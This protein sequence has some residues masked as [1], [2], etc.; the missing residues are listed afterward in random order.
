MDVYVDA[1]FF[2]LIPPQ[3]LQQ[4]GWHYELE[5]LEAPLTYKGVVFNE[6]KGA[7]SSPENLL[8]RY[9]QEALFPDTPYGVDSGGDPQAIPN[10]TYTQ[11]KSFHETYYH[12]SNAYIFMYG[13]DDP[14]TRLRLMS[15]YLQPFTRRQVD[16]AVPVQPP[17]AAPRSITVPYAA[18]EDSESSKGYVTVNWL[19]AENRDPETIL[20]LSIL[21]HILIGTPASPL[22]KALIDSGLGEDLVGSGLEPE[23]RQ[24]YFSTGLKGLSVSDQL[25]VENVAEVEALIFETL[26][27]LARDGIDPETVFASLNTTE[28]RLRENNTGSF[29]RGLLLMLRALTTW[30]YDGDPA[31]ALAFE[32]PLESIKARLKAGQPYFEDLI[33]R[34]LLNNPHRSTVVLQPDPGLQARLDAAE[35]ERLAAARLAMSPQELQDIIENAESLKRQQ[36][37]PDSPEVLALIPSLKLEDLDRQN[38]PIPLELLDLDGTPLLYHDLFTNGILYLDVGF[39]LHA[40]PQELLPYLPLFGRALVEIGT[41]TQDFVRLSQRIGRST[42]GIHASFFTS[43]VTELDDPAAWFFL[44]GKAV[45]SQTGELLSILQDILLTV[46]LDNPERF[47]QM[48]LES[49][50]DLEAMLV[51]AGHR[52]VN[53]RLKSRF[54]QSAWL[55]EQMGGISYL[56]FLRELANQVDQDWPS[57]LHKLETIRKLLI[58]RRV[59]LCNLTIDS[60]NWAVIQPQLTSFLAALPAPAASRH[61]WSPE[62]VAYDEALTI[63]AQVNYVGK[64]ADLYQLGYR[65]DGSLFVILNYLRTTYLWEKI[66]VQGGAYGGFATFD[67]RSGVFTY[68][69]YRDPNL[70]A[71]IENYDRTPHFLR[72]IDGSRL[73]QEE[74]TKSIIGVIGDLDAYQLPD[75]KGFSS[76]T[77]FLAGETDQAR[78]QRR[79]QVLAT[80]QDDFRQFSQVLE[81]V[82]RQ[83]QVVVLGSQESINA[84]DAERGGWLRITRVL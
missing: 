40:I 72:E 62:F 5:S 14:Q 11:F 18:G 50:A 49:K 7:Y 81:E 10:L 19:L 82:S 42:G 84:A 35:T 27:G 52:V 77:R 12:P 79:E 15:E 13:D 2:P 4:E 65:L 76:L 33:R 54:D 34:Y 68:L 57:V 75:A 1:V 59:M 38:K 66:R 22:R 44:R 25:Q 41:Q 3:T 23:L 69:S 45:A 64:G 73:S 29:P 71:T 61:T 39:D 6:M 74:L 8:A 53:T 31:S 55:D 51:P 78:Q 70:L 24:A 30:L 17:F 37:A 28:F 48:V 67:H 32:S 16:S 26:E 46:Q 80:K 9:S 63:P 47:R 58:N 60:E 56:F 21:S 43:A 20:G 36:E 83:G